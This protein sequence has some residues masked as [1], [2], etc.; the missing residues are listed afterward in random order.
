MSVSLFRG[1]GSQTIVGSL[2]LAATQRDSTR[3]NSGFDVF[4][5]GDLL[6]KVPF[7]SLLGIDVER[8]SGF[9]DSAHME[10]EL[11]WNTNKLT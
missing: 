6:Y 9:D 5:L 8:L 7:H 3:F 10:G 4:S 1:G 2:P 11:D